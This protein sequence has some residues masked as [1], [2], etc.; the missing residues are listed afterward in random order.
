MI[1]IRGRKGSARGAIYALGVAVLVTVSIPSA[2]AEDRSRSGQVES[3]AASCEWWFGHTDAVTAATTCLS[4]F[5]QLSQDQVVD[6][7]NRADVQGTA[8]SFASATS[9]GATIIESLVGQAVIQAEEL[10]GLQATFDSDLTNRRLAVG[11]TYGS[12]EVYQNIV[13]LPIDEL[14]EDGVVAQS[15]GACRDVSISDSVSGFKWRNN[16][17]L[18]WVPNQQRCPNA[19]FDGLGKISFY[20]QNKRINEKFDF[21]A[22]SQRASVMSRYG[23]KLVTLATGI[24][25]DAQGLEAAEWTPGAVDQYGSDSVSLNIG[26]GPLSISRTWSR[27]AGYTGAHMFHDDFHMTYWEKNSGDTYPKEVAGVEIWKITRAKHAHWD[28]GGFARGK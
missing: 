24:W 15:C 13:L 3:A 1:R 5:Q 17:T 8:Q 14:L 9:A 18:K 25:P 16:A 23:K 27:A 21:W 19:C 7:L 2:H 22:T 12:T 20:K 26:V 4:Y 11:V 10:T 28:Y 6:S